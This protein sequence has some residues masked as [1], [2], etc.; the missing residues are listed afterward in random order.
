MNTDPDR[1]SETHCSGYFYRWYFQWRYNGNMIA[2]DTRTIPENVVS[3]Y[4]LRENLVTGERRWIE[5]V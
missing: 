2:T 5:E 3:V 4:R 1:F